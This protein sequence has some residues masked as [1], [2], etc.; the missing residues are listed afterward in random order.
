MLDQVNSEWI[1]SEK[2]KYFELEDFV[3][4]I[5]IDSRI[6]ELLAETDD[7]FEE[8]IK[9]LRKLYDNDL[10]GLIYDWLDQGIKE[11]MFSN[12][13]ENHRIYFKDMANSDLFFEKLSISHERIKRIH[14]FVCEKGTTHT[15]IV[16]DYRK[17]AATVGKKINGKYILYWNGVEAQ[18][19]KTFMDSFIKVYKTNSVKEVYNNPFLKA[20][21]AHLLFVRIHPF[22]DG[23]GRTSRII[24][25]I[26]FTNGINR[27]YGSKLK[28]SPLNISQGITVTKYV[29]VDIL[30]RI[31]FNLDFDNNQ[32][33]NDWFKYMLYRYQDQ[34]YLQQSRFGSCIKIYRHN[35]HKP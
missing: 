13:L 24:Q 29:Y 9:H 8:Y 5:K 27:I 15:E 20:A 17:E 14:R 10:D 33:I 11:Q 7:L 4:K 16:G 18:D 26:A 23:N 12:E 35:K 22:G 21:L 2:I 31:H 25:N 30:N 34:I 32:L 3:D 6:Y 19:I 1:N 28:L